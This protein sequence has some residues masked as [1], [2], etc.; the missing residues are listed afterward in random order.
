MRKNCLFVWKGTVQAL[1]CKLKWP[2]FAL[3]ESKCLTFAQKY[4]PKSF[5][6]RQRKDSLGFGEYHPDITIYI[7]FRPQR[8]KK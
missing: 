4:G 8:N 7:H 3:S 6:L 2:V 1:V 5:C